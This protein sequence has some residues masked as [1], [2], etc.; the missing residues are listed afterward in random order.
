MQKIKSQS[1]AC[2]AETAWQRTLEAFL[3]L[4]SPKAGM[5]HCSFQ[6]QTFPYLT[7]LQ[8][9]GSTISTTH[10]QEF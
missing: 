9:L 2:H 10:H 1:K 4:P 3:A 5:S 8:P 6:P 7:L